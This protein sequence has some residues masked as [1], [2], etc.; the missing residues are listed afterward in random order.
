MKDAMRKTLAFLVLAVIAAVIFTVTSVAG[1]ASAETVYT[2]SAE[3]MIVLERDTERVLNE[4]NADKK[5]PMAS[6]TKIAT[7]ITVIDNVTDLDKIVR[8]PRFL[9][10]RGLGRRY[11]RQLP[12]LS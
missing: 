8:V 3:C 10:A 2:G 11:V 1:R 12:S 7:A 9:C 6:T 4:N 5:R